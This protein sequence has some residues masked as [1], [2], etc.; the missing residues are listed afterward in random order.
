MAAAN[1]ISRL[2]DVP[3]SSAKAMSRSDFLAAAKAIELLLG[4]IYGV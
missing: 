2:A 3:L 1:L 4:S